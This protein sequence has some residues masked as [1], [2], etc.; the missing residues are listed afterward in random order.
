MM[1]KPFNKSIC[2]SFFK[3]KNLMR[4]LYLFLFYYFASNF[5]LVKMNDFQRLLGLNDS[6]GWNFVFEDGGN[7]SVKLLYLKK[8]GEG[9][10]GTV[11]KTKLVCTKN[12]ACNWEW[13]N[14]G[15]GL[16]YVIS[17]E[18]Q[19]R[20]GNYSLAVSE[21]SDS[22][23]NLNSTEVAFKMIHET[24]KGKEKRLRI[25]YTRI[26]AIY[27]AA[28]DYVVKPLG[29]LQT[30]NTVHYAYLMPI[31]KG[32]M[33]TAFNNIDDLV[34]CID[35]V[36]IG[37]GKIHNEGILH[38][39]FKLKNIFVND[40][41]QCFIADPNDR[42]A[43]PVFQN[44]SER[45]KSISHKMLHEIE[46]NGKDSLGFLRARLTEITDFLELCKVLAKKIRKQLKT[47]RLLFELR[48]YK[49]RVITKVVTDEYLNA[50]FEFKKNE[51]PQLG[52]D[53]DFG[54]F[55][56]KAA[57]FSDE[58]ENQKAKEAVDMILKY[59]KIGEYL[60][61]KLMEDEKYKKEWSAAME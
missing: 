23:T 5:G 18:Q 59:G 33:R 3:S 9:S 15:N 28:P 7:G 6:E 30:P 42:F 10:I 26:C 29:L 1:N 38:G 8:L 21:N 4:V 52:G 48:H 57:N 58:D 36:F 22:R 54:E 19:L 41:N 31:Y 45:E 61:Y 17:G 53:G 51:H 56:I 50:I 39:D 24:N 35:K 2:G 12:L 20:K 46:G 60:Q 37:I 11:Y 40:N 16:K 14:I 43:V 25:E 49:N 13:G 47:G 55:M 34:G 27:N 32:D 44:I